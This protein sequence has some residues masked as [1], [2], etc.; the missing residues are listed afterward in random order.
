MKTRILTRSELEGLADMAA[1]VEAVEA[2]FRA[3]AEGKS[4]MPPKVYLTL[5]GGDFRAMPSTVEGAAGI[6]WVSSHPENPA[7]HGLPAVM[8]VYI[9]SDPAC[10][11]PLAVLDGTLI[12][13]L[14]TGAAAGVATKHLT[15]GAPSTVGFVGCGVQAHFALH[16]HRV[17]LG[18]GFEALCADLRPDAAE[19][20]AKEIRDQGLSARAVTVEE[21][22]GAEI[23]NATTPGTRVAV[24]ARWVRPNAHV[25]AMGADA[26]GKQELATDLLAKAQIIIDEHHQATHSG[27]VNVPLAKG[28]LSES[29][30][31]GNLGDVIL[32]KIAVDQSRL[33]VFDST[34][35]AVQD[36]ATARL[37]FDEAQAAGV[38]TEVDL[39]GLGR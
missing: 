3:H 36:V 11:F 34:G 9:L 16:A 18:D 22:A 7:R 2:A 25:N 6:K 39:I 26:P 10:A 38:G 8:G 12:T 27:E 17:V 21:A 15:S 30:L 24:E 28:A 32:G 33:T 20:F 5:P 23:V 19:A 1:I 29:D 13:A 4:Q 37:L 14:R 35:L 31:T